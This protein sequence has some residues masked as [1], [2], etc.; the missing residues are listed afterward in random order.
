MAHPNDTP[1]ALLTIDHVLGFVR[2]HGWRLVL[3]GLLGGALGGALSF[4]VAKQWQAQVTLQI[5]RVFSQGNAM[6]VERPT[7]AVARLQLAVFRDRVL[8]ALSLPLASED[9]PETA[10]LRSSLHAGVLRTTD[11]VTVSVRAP[12]AEQA[13]RWLVAV[14]AILAEDHAQL[15]RP[16]VGRLESEWKDIEADYPVAVARRDALYERALAG[17][18]TPEAWSAMESVLRETLINQ[19]EQSVRTLQLRRATV[20][21]QLSPD[22]TFNTRPMNGVDVSRRPVFPSRPLF[23]VVGAVL[24]GL[25]VFVVCVVCDY[26]RARALRPGGSA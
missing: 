5:G 12:S 15:L 1:P 8:Q 4:G 18:N 20:A 26:R 22:L 9:S 21:E 11:L 14:N 19:I 16:S 24:A 2:R 17:S 23:A 10:M 6:L 25:L 3:A 7:E 13:E